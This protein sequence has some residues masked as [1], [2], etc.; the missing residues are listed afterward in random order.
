MT[1]NLSSSF[2][3]RVR[4]VGS[5]TVGQDGNLYVLEKFVPLP[6][7]W[8]TATVSRAKFRPDF[9]GNGNGSKN[10]PDRSVSQLEAATRKSAIEQKFPCSQARALHQNI[11]GVG[12][13]VLPDLALFEKNLCGYIAEG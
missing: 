5:M 8:N 3:G 12:H 10:S 13:Q 6:N 7:C 2:R 1:Y 11:S 4:D 9:A